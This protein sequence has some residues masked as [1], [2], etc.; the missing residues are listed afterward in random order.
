[1]VQLGAR[2]QHWQSNAQTKRK[3][4][5][6]L[7]PVAHEVDRNLVGELQIGEQ[8]GCDEEVLRQLVIIR[9]SHDLIKDHAT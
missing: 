8:F 5:R 6:Q 1:M 2:T 9:A 7:L 4:G 3:R